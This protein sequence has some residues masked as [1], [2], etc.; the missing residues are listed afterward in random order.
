MMQ[1]DG[2][3]M[4]RLKHGGGCIQQLLTLPVSFF[5]QMDELD[6]IEDILS[7]F[8][9]DSGLQTHILDYSYGSVD[10]D[11]HTL[12]VLFCCRHGNSTGLGITIEKRDGRWHIAEEWN[13]TYRF[14][15]HCERYDTTLVAF[16]P[17]H[18][19]MRQCDDNSLTHEVTRSI[20]VNAERL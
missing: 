8:V 6:E 14:C 2:I 15:P 11:G 20:P 17:L 4:L 5:Q 12:R 9:G 10:G 19:D 1:R 13:D 7:R 18:R 3:S 16:S